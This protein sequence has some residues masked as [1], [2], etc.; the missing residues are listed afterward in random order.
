MK[1]C[2]KCRQP[3]SSNEYY[4]EKAIYCKACLSLYGKKYYQAKIKHSGIYHQI[5]PQKPVVQI[6]RLSPEEYNI[7]KENFIKWLWEEEHAS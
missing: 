4:G 6:E 2:K 3:K 5:V 1:T 7:R